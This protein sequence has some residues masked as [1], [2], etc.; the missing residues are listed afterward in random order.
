MFQAY[1]E[2][3]P[4]GKPDERRHCAQILPADVKQIDRER[5]SWLAAGKWMVYWCWIRSRGYIC[6][7][8]A[9][10]SDGSGDSTAPISTA[11]GAVAQSTTTHTPCGSRLDDCTKRARRRADGIEGE[12]NDTRS[13]FSKAIDTVALGGAAPGEPWLGS[14]SFEH[15]AQSAIDF[16]RNLAKLSAEVRFRRAVPEA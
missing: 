10:R 13:G 1:C 15:R 11:G 6:E 8:P 2:R 16:G 5:V 12:I 3:G 4:D 7:R 14:A 9:K